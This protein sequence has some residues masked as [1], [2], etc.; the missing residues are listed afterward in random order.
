MLNLKNKKIMK[1]KVLFSTLLSGALLAACTADDALDVNKVADKV[2]PAAPVFTVSFGN[3]DLTRADMPELGGIKWTKD[4]KMSLF[5]GG[6]EKNTSSWSGLDFFESNVKVYQRNAVYAAEESDGTGKVEYK[7]AAMVVPGAA[8][9]VYPADLGFTQDWNN[10]H[11]SI[12]M[13]Q[14]GAD[15]DTGVKATRDYTPYVSEVL[16]LENKAG[17]SNVAG[18]DKKYDIVMRRIGGLLN[19][20][21]D[22]V[23][24]ADFSKIK[25]KEVKMEVTD[26]ADSNPF[27]KE[28]EIKIG[29]NRNYSTTGGVTKTELGGINTNTRHWAYTPWIEPTADGKSNKIST[30]DI[31]KDTK[32]AFFTLLPHDDR[33]GKV[34]SEKEEDLIVLKNKAG[35]KTFKLVKPNFKDLT[36]TVNTNY[37][38]VVYKED[39]TTKRWHHGTDWDMTMTEGLM[40]FLFAAFHPQ[41]AWKNKNGDVQ[42]VDTRYTGQLMANYGER[43]LTIKLADLDMNYLHIENEEDLND[44]L[45]VY[46]KLVKPTDTKGVVL[47]LDGAKAGKKNPG[48]FTMTEGT[49]T[50]LETRFADP[51]NKVKLALCAKAGEACTAVVLDN[52]EAEAAEVP[53]LQFVT[54]AGDESVQE[55]RVVELVGE[56]KYTDV[57]ENANKVANATLK[58]LDIDQLTVTK[59][60]TIVLQNYIKAKNPVKLF[61]ENGADVT[62]S[63]VVTLQENM[64]NFGKIKIGTTAASTDQLAVDNG[65]SLWN[66]E[67]ILTSAQ[68]T[69]YWW[70]TTTDKGG[71][72]DVYS[73]LAIV[74]G[75][76]GKIY[77]RGVINMESE[78]AIV[79]ITNNQDGPSYANVGRQYTPSTLEKNSDQQNT[80]RFGTINLN[81]GVN[82][83]AVTLTIQQEYNGFVKYNMSTGTNCK[84]ANYCVVDKAGD[85]PTTNVG[86]KTY[87]E[88]L[89][90][91]EIAKDLNAIINAKSYKDPLSALIV[92]SGAK[93]YI[94]SDVTLSMETT[95]A[96]LYV[97]GTVT[98]AINF[99]WTD[100]SRN[101]YFGDGSKGGIYSAGGK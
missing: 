99:P 68:L 14:V 74:S 2:N 8:I 1:N 3:D 70:N 78:S 75:S 65:V 4:D 41:E 54:E 79:L 20:K 96:A 84:L 23:D 13:D 73:T 83:G 95:N 21:L 26:N 32:T 100:A 7:T 94:P 56:W 60:A 51:N 57:T 36:I 46:D 90:Y 97:N 67:A 80:C 58:A 29:K 38:K 88:G 82:T 22:A 15:K 101:N 93:V 77:N 47:I 43:T 16:N 10:P 92:P 91:I 53:A 11:I 37:G 63:G 6:Q 76:T 39:N 19:L 49:W 44:V 66:R 62:V 61:V 98:H 33:E 12:S 59:D 24:G 85:F 5:H 71:V 27:T 86:E 87:H 45:G 55:N 89:M 42:A 52:G 72:I 30:T 35:N 40:E 9:M 69:E 31:N 18:Y 81:G 48:K 17:E 28:M 25:Y 64:T 50:A 34:F